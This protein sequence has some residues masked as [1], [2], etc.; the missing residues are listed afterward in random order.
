[1]WPGRP[2][3]VRAGGLHGGAGFRVQ[4]IRTCRCGRVDKSV[5][6]ARGRDREVGSGGGRD[7]LCVARNAHDG[8][9]VK[10]EQAEQKKSGALIS[11]APLFH[12]SIYRLA[13]TASRTAS[14]MPP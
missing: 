13:L 5:S 7:A 9:Y 10:A 1:M 12:A 3:D 11:E 2:G 6:A 4:R 8:H 14:I